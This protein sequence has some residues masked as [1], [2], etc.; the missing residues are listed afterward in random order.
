MKKKYLVWIFTFILVYIIYVN[1]IIITVK[2]LPDFNIDDG[3]SSS[4]KFTSNQRKQ[5]REF[6]EGKTFIK[7]MN[8][9]ANYDQRQDGFENISLYVNDRK[10]NPILVNKNYIFKK[11]SYATIRITISKTN[12]LDGSKIKLDG[13]YYKLSNDD[14]RRLSKILENETD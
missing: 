10:N 5:V 8:I 14:A 2:T 13:K 7:H 12:L 9:F 11:K 4:K 3:Y 1:P 6:I